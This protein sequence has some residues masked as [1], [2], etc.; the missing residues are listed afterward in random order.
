MSK[1]AVHDVL[2]NQQICA[3]HLML[4]IKAQALQFCSLHLV[5]VDS[6][7]VQSRGRCRHE[8][9]A[10]VSEQLVHHPFHTSLDSL[11]LLIVSAVQ[12]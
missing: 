3:Y 9:R 6:E 12:L 11:H 10:R 1:V 4:V 5:A 7:V 2:V 8:L